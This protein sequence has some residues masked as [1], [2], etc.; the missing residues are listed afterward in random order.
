MPNYAR[1][2]PA[3]I[4]GGDTQ[5]TVANTASGAVIAG[6]YA[7]RW[8]WCVGGCTSAGTP[9]GSDAVASFSGRGPSRDGRTLPSVVAPGVGVISSQAMTAS[10]YAGTGTSHSTPV[11]SGAV[12]LLL[13]QSPTLTAS[14]VISLLTA[15][16]AHDAFTGAGANNDY[17]AGKLDAYGA[18]ARLVDG[19]STAAQTIVQYE[20]VSAADVTVPNGGAASV[21]VTSPLATTGLVR[22]VLFHTA[23]TTTGAPVRLDVRADD[24]AGSP[25]SLLGTITQ[26][27]AAYR[28]GTWNYVDLTALGLSTPPGGTF[29]LVVAPTSGTLGLRADAAA[30]TDRSQLDTGAALRRPR[31]RP[32]RARRPHRCP[33]RADR[34]G[35]QVGGGRCGLAPARRAGHAHHRGHAR[36]A[37]PRA[38]HRA[39]LSGRQPQPAHGLRRHRV[40]GARRHRHRARAGAGLCVVPLQ[41]RD[42][43]RRREPERAAAVYPPRRH[44]APHDRPRGDAP[45]QRRRLE[46]PRQPVRGALRVD[47]LRRWNGAERLTSVVGQV[48]EDAAGEGT[49]GSYV[50]T[51]LLGDAVPPFAGFFVQA[52]QAGT[53]TL[54]AAAQDPAFVLAKQQQA[55]PQALVAFELTGTTTTGAPTRDRAA[56]LVLRDDARDAWDAF[57]AAKLEPLA[58]RYAIV[59][60]DGTDAAG[61]PVL[62]A[63]D[64]HPLTAPGRLSLPLSIVAS[65]VAPG[66][67]LRWPRIDGLPEAW[68][69]TLEDR[70]TGA[71]RDLRRD[72]VYR[73]DLAADALGKADATAGWHRRHARR[74]RARAHPPPVYGRRCGAAPGAAPRP[75]R[76]HGPR[77]RLGTQQRCSPSR[78]SCP[79]RRTG[80]YASPSRSR[81]PAPRRWRCTT[82]SGAAWRRRS[83]ATRL[84]CRCGW[85]SMRTRSRRACTFSA[86]PPEGRRA[87]PALSWRASDPGV[88][89]LCSRP[90]LALLLATAAPALPADSLVRVVS[91]N[92]RY[93]NPGDGEHAWPLR[94]D[95]VANLLR[96]Y[97]PD[98][99]GLQEALQ[100]QIDDLVARLPQYAW[101]GVG[102]DDGRSAGEGTPIFYR[103]D[104][105]TLLDQGTFWLSETPEV[106]GSKSW[107]AA[108][109]RIATWGRFVDRTTG[110]RFL[111][112]NTHFDHIGQTARE[113]SAATHRGPARRAVPR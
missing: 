23:T 88:P 45:R 90:S 42:R 75:G 39:Q 105:F 3:T 2:I 83:R 47:E 87:R 28:A 24:G 86:S 22:G 101:F 113:R 27:A 50:P 25:G 10:H 51:S 17:G 40:D 62:K 13:E 74:D 9:D 81:P 16:A 58:G 48:W 5:S 108:I 99:F 41:P 109:T 71:T 93:N 61:R 35:V 104:R 66:L 82:R 100:G 14:A 78:P 12:A 73:F 55:L 111:Y 106:P 96:F 36:P 26:P 59:G 110:T 80:W 20:G 92:I 32:A 31:A 107:D 97:N 18:M 43:P 67:T 72:S 112:L 79:T 76:R 46:S 1:T 65:G 44:R 98:L 60:F 7:A 34:A 37:E 52:A 38:G 103:R 29:H 95:R 102:R 8:A 54:P 19:G 4:V 63:Q 68:R 84:P 89:R 69:L 11:V 77:R 70:L 64:A 56:V 49:G 53:L 21:R 6:A 15:T 57:D 30:T 33:R 91:Y 85:A 94:A